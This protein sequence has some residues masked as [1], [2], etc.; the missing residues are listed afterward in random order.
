MSGGTMS[1]P[2]G[3]LSQEQR[4]RLGQA[5]R[6]L[7]IEPAYQ[8]VG[9]VSYAEV[10][11]AANI[12]TLHDLSKEY[13]AEVGQWVQVK[14]TNGDKEYIELD[15]QNL[16]PEKYQAVQHALK[17]N[18]VAFSTGQPVQIDASGKP[19][20]GSG[21]RIIVSMNSTASLDVGDVSHLSPEEQHALLE[22]FHD[23]IVNNW[24]DDDPESAKYADAM[25]DMLARESIDKLTHIVN[26]YAPQNLIS[27]KTLS[28]NPAA[29]LSNVK[30]STPVP[31]GY[32]ESNDVPGS[33]RNG[34]QKQ[35]R[36]GVV[37]NRNSFTQEGLAEDGVNPA[38]RDPRYGQKPSPRNTGNGSQEVTN[39]N[40]V[41]GGQP[42]N[43]VTKQVA[44][45]GVANAAINGG[46]MPDGKTNSV[47]EPEVNIAPK[48]PSAITG[49]LSVAASGYMTYGGIVQSAE[50]ISLIQN[51]QVGKG[52]ANLGVGA[53]NATM[54]I[55]GA[56]ETM[57]PGSLEKMAGSVI[58]ENFE[59]ANLWVMAASAVVTIATANSAD[60]KGMAAV[61]VTGSM[62]P[63]LLVGEIA[64]GGAA[65]II[66]PIG[67]AAGAGMLINR[68]FS[69]DKLELQH[70][71]AM[72][73]LKPDNTHTHLR[74][75]A[76]KL[77]NTL[78]LAQL[79]DQLVKAQDGTIDMANQTN[80]DKAK[81]TLTD[82][83]WKTLEAACIKQ[84][85]AM[86][87]DYKMK[88]AAAGSPDMSTAKEA[89]DE[90]NG[91]IHSL[92]AQSLLS[93]MQLAV[94]ARSDYFPKDGVLAL[95]K[96]GKIDLSNSKN[97]D[98]LR[99]VFTRES[100]AA[101]KVAIDTQ[102]ATYYWNL[103]DGEA[104]LRQHI[105]QEELRKGT[106]VALAEL[107]AVQWGAVPNSHVERTPEQSQT[108]VKAL[109]D[110][111]VTMAKTNNG[112]QNI[113]TDFFY[114]ADTKGGDVNGFTSTNDRNAP[115]PAD[116]MA[117]YSKDYDSR[118]ALGLPHPRISSIDQVLFKDDGHGNQVAYGVVVWHIVD[119]QE[120][121]KKDIA[122]G[123]QQPRNF[124]DDVAY[125]ASIDGNGVQMA[126]KPSALPAASNNGQPL[127]NADKGVSPN[128]QQLQNLITQH[129][130]LKTEANKLIAY[131]TN[132]NDGN[133]KG[134]D[135][136]GKEFLGDANTRTDGAIDTP[137]MQA[138][139][140][141]LQ[142]DFKNSD[143]VTDNGS[144]T[145]IIAANNTQAGKS[146]GRT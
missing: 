26:D 89:E 11:G 128:E 43:G 87:D 83:Q 52:V 91:L 14:P 32:E 50:G 126:E 95:D 76:D 56:A 112:Q 77:Q 106:D 54:G 27:P 135:A 130:E 121:Q 113:V 53:V 114:V 71:K 22:E 25:K 19:V 101:S 62:V 92:E 6:T 143:I 88:A 47:T 35:G 28:E 122:E 31:P 65:G 23:E 51:G 136:S 131:Y 55:M 41:V 67:V 21:Q 58:A 63:S 3:D 129:P 115:I 140:R 145:L 46:V 12:N 2:I 132:G 141:K 7:G 70:I 100:D 42:A 16:P 78:I 29:T 59:K 118:Q 80:F 17:L 102:R 20:A 48:T 104:T 69:M 49:S 146:G 138:I 75:E 127:A 30:D 124:I 134:I 73:D 110:Q 116:I 109:Y 94:Q 119:Q 33:I 34:S 98:V 84:A 18:D 57:A 144:G 97:M 125:S 60:D 37:Q 90:R 137:E 5:L 36:G 103:V 111:A 66:L 64:G 108:E 38:A 40:A 123:K 85:D 10:S 117:A 79:G 15:A 139:L 82:A 61:H 4:A 99:E 39:A 45:D 93:P 81:A 105:A 142:T 86:L 13:I 133:V 72:D 44:Q 24:I 74:I 107:N 8:E 1:L 9:G 120:M 68:A 96:D